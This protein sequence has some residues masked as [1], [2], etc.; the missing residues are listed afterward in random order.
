MQSLNRF[1]TML[2][3]RLN[4]RW[5][6][7]TEHCRAKLPDL[8]QNLRRKVSQ[9]SAELVSE[10]DRNTT[11]FMRGTDNLRS[12]DGAYH[13]ANS[14]TH[15]HTKSVQGSFAGLRCVTAAECFACATLA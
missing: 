10:Q 1:E 6:I 4:C 9:R 8:I 13:A 5:L 7:I 14:Q 12:A 11:G 2:A 15:G 3:C